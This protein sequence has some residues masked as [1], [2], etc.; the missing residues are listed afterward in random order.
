MSPFGKAGRVPP[1]VRAQRRRMP[2][3]GWRSGGG[4]R[5]QRRLLR[6]L[7][8]PRGQGAGPAAPG[9]RAP[10]LWPRPRPS[11]VGGALTERRSGPPQP[12]QR[13]P[14]AKN[15]RP[16]FG[17]LPASFPVPSASFHSLTFASTSSAA[18]LASSVQRAGDRWREGG[19]QRKRE[20]PPPSRDE[21]AAANPE[22]RRPL[23]PAQ[24]GGRA[25]GA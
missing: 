15:K 19:R 13:P 21:A 11:P 6:G 23:A 22:A 17:P 8:L 9:R 2:G 12:P 4:K 20:E 16:F 18:I 14:G 7:C 25:A 3:G 5:G 10:P 24:K 1:G